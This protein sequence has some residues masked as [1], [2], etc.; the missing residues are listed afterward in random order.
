[1]LTTCRPMPAPSRPPATSRWTRRASSICRARSPVTRAATAAWPA[2]TK[3]GTGT[4]TLGGAGADNTNL[5]LVVQ[6]GT[7]SLN[8]ASSPSV[9]AALAVAVN[10]AP[11]CDIPAAAMVRLVTGGWVHLSG[12]TLDLSGQ[13]QTGTDISVSTAG[14]T[15]ANTASSTT[16]V[17]TPNS[18]SYQNSLTVNTVGNLE[19]N[20]AI[21]G[22]T[23]W[24]ALTKTGWH[25]N[26][27]RHDRQHLYHID[28]ITRDREAQQDKHSPGA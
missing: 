15:L 27:Q 11:W 10:A 6:D 2:L 25:A 21:V 18:F 16:L 5:T 17:Y 14:S 19:I 26:S 24:P 4:L 13:N 1:M 12:G 20:G 22:D 28:R 3:T 7:V 23:T 9:H 8:K